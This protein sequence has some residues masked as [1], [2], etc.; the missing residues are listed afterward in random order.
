M[1]EVPF[2]GDASFLAELLE[3]VIATTAEGP[4]SFSILEQLIFLG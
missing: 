2:Q 3:T 1:N 4:Q